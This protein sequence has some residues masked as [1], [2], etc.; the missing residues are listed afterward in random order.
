VER[1]VMQQNQRHGTQPELLQTFRVALVPEFQEKK[2]SVGGNL[3]LIPF[4][5]DERFL[6]EKRPGKPGRLLV[7]EPAKGL[8][9]PSD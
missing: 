2:F 7:F 6:N 8:R 5:S 1:Q 4:S 9:N 3:S